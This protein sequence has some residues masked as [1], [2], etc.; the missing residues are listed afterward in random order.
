MWDFVVLAVFFAVL[1]L[2]FV[3]ASRWGR[4]N[5]IDAS[6]ETEPTNEQHRRND[7][8]GVGKG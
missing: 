4:R 7:E 1:V 2:F 3:W 8:N 6:D 5:H